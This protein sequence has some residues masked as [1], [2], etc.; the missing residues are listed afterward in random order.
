MA[1]D[2]TERGRRTPDG[3]SRSLSSPSGVSVQHSGPAES[4]VLQ[5]GQRYVGVGHR[6]RHGG[7]LDPEPHRQREEGL[8]V[9]R[10]LAVTLISRRSWKSVWS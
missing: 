1:G 8:P 5:V 3:L 10:V 7:G 4:T 6:V 9:V 2:R